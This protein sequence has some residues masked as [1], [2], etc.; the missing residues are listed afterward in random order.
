VLKLPERHIKTLYRVGSL[1]GWRN[2]TADRWIDEGRI[3]HD[4]VEPDEL[5]GAYGERILIQIENTRKGTEWLDRDAIADELSQ[6]RYPLHFVDIE[7]SSSPLP[8]HTGMRPY[9]VVPFQW[10]CHTIAEPDAEPTHYDY[11]NALAHHPGVEFLKSLRSAV[12]TSGTVLIWSKYELTQ[13]KNLRDRV[14]RESDSVNIGL[15]HA[16]GQ[17]STPKNADNATPCFPSACPAPTTPPRHL[18]RWSR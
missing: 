16:V 9:E 2:P 11:L 13:L 4:D 10:S 12:G 1:G 3:E 8:H 7:T 5:T 15:C 17:G 6:W 14:Q 18:S